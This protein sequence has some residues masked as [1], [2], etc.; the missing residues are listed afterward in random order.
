MHLSILLTLKAHFNPQGSKFIG[1]AGSDVP[2][3]SLSCSAVCSGSLQKQVL[4]EVSYCEKGVLSPHHCQIYFSL[5]FYNLYLL[6]HNKRSFEHVLCGINIE[7][8]QTG[9]NN[10][11]CSDASFLFK[12]FVLKAG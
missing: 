4:P 9:K 11:T 10:K 6:I 2:K 1:R 8:F 3:A 5:I 7:N 12:E